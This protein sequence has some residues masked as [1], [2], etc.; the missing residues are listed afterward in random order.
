MLFKN[1]NPPSKFTEDEYESANSDPPK[2]FLRACSDGTPL[3]IWVIVLLLH[4][5]Y[6]VALRTFVRL[7][8]DQLALIVEPKFL[9]F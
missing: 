2:F 7:M 6:T 3:S 1:P 5:R 8:T 9:R 4:P